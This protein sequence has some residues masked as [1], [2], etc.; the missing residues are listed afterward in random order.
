MS[1]DVCP[2]NIKFAK[3]LPDESPFAPREALG[4]K[5]AR[6]LARE[7][8]TLSQDEFSA[9]FKSSPT[10]TCSREHAGWDAATAQR[11]VNS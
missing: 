10:R 7:P 8:L 5:D 2:W 3:L 6:Q 9:A 1:Q 4:G 11:R